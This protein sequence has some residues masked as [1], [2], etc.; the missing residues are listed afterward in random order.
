MR[1]WIRFLIYGIEGKSSRKDIFPYCPPPPEWLALMTTPSFY[2]SMYR[3]TQM[4]DGSCPNEGT[5]LP[6]VK[7]KSMQTN[8][9]WHGAK[10]FSLLGLH[11]PSNFLLSKLI[12]RCASRISYCRV[13]SGPAPGYLETEAAIFIPPLRNKSSLLDWNR[14]FRAWVLL[15]HLM[16][17]SPSATG[18]EIGH[19]GY[20]QFHL[21][22]WF[23]ASGTGSAWRG[24]SASLSPLHMKRGGGGRVL[25]P[26]S[27][28]H[29]SILFCHA[30]QA[31]PFS[32][33]QHTSGHLLCP[34]ESILSSTQTRF[35]PWMEKL[36]GI[37]DSVWN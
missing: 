16:N 9:P 10:C 36:T 8:H 37:S 2:V 30:D 35:N 29:L 25:L 14:N 28:L 19:F 24:L 32:A 18:Q 1:G 23:I 31:L 7:S 12:L 26:L 13:K 22:I 4:I 6:W 27:G 21:C 5:D 11:A 17:S 3:N 34:L 33:A 15:W 20:T